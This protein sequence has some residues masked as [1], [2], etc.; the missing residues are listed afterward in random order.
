M[1]SLPQSVWL[2]TGRKHGQ[3]N[4]QKPDLSRFKKILTCVAGLKKPQTDSELNPT[5]P[6]SGQDT[7][8]DCP[9]F[10]SGNRGWQEFTTWV[11]RRL[12]GTSVHRTCTARHVASRILLQVWSPDGLCN[13]EQLHPLPVPPHAPL[14]AEAVTS[15]PH[16]SV[17]LAR[18]HALTH[19]SHP[20]SL[21]YFSL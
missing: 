19:S 5:P 10:H 16:P 13:W 14:K 9:C 17:T 18:K 20:D 6:P 8:A 4:V 21:R 7:W 1:T 15:M 2:F 11:V 12:K 3:I